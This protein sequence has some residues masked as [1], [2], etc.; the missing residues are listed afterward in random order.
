MH[1]FLKK[2]KHGSLI[3]LRA[4]RLSLCFIQ[5]FSNHRALWDSAEDCRLLFV[6]TH[7]ILLTILRIHP[8]VVLKALGSQDKYNKVDYL[9]WSR[10]FLCSLKVMAH[11][12]LTKTL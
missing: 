4:R 7:K 3:G 6:Y 12:I 2:V 10:Y 11:L 5:H 8:I 9:C 1:V